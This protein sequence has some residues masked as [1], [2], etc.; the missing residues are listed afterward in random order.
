MIW[1]GGG[2]AVLSILILKFLPVPFAWLA[3]LWAATAAAGI[4][5]A[6]SRYLKLAC[7]S[8]MSVLVS[9]AVA[10][11]VLAFLAVAPPERRV[12][13]FYYVPDPVLGWR[14]RPGL[15]S[16]DVERI[17]GKL[18]YDVT[19]TIDAAGRR[20]SL[21][22]AASAPRGASCSSGA[23][24]PSARECPTTQPFPIEPASCPADD[25]RSPTSPRPGTGRSTCWRCWS[26]A[27]FG[28]GLPAGPPT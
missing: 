26:V 16:R 2:V 9:L 14:L 10:E 12:T 4:V 21:R 7:V 11:T 24:R 17:D 18:F 15:V 20:V 22:T 5:L 13:P 8:G 23:R 28:S 1:L 25:S 19:Y 3:L 27:R 6:R